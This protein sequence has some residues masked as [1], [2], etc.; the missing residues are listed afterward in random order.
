MT[1]TALLVPQQGGVSL[2]ALFWGTLL[3][4]AFW[5][6]SGVHGWV[7][8]EVRVHLRNHVT[9]SATHSAPCPP[10][11]PCVPPRFCL[12]RARKSDLPS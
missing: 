6:F 1:L 4:E 12:V 3:R 8:L 11:L 10:K 9:F 7:C 2:T 5:L